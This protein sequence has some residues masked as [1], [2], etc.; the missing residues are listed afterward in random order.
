[1]DRR[2][3]EMYHKQKQQKRW[4]VDFKNLAYDGGGSASWTQYY[5]TKAGALLSKFRHLYISSCGGQ[6]TLVDTYGDDVPP[7]IEFEEVPSFTGWT[8]KVA[9]PEPGSRPTGLPPR[10]Q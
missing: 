4:R 1:M 2:D 8:K 9:P 10:R 5:L 6:A 3:Y 7:P